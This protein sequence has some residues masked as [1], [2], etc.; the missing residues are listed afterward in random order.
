MELGYT[1]MLMSSYVIVEEE[2]YM[3]GRGERR[4]ERGEGLYERKAAQV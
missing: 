3:G 4:L 1:V 2:E